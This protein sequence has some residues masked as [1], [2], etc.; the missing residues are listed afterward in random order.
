VLAGT[1]S[2]AAAKDVLDTI[3]EKP[4]L[5]IGTSSDTPLSNIDH[6]I[7]EAARVLPDVLREFLTREGINGTRRSRTCLPTSRPDG[8]T[9]R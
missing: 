2:G 4:V 3:L 8:S 6:K 7:N 9:L 1:G 5:V